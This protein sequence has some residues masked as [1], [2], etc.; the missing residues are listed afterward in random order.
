MFIVVGPTALYLLLGFLV[1][2]VCAAWAAAVAADKYSNLT[3]DTRRAVISGLVVIA[4]VCA[5]VAVIAAYLSK[6]IPTRG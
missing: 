4:F 2:A 1:S 5:P 6:P 3:P